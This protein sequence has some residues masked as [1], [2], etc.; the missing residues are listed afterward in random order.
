MFIIKVEFICSST[1]TTLLFLYSIK[2]LAG[3]RICLSKTLSLFSLIVAYF[4][5][6]PSVVSAETPI[7]VFSRSEIPASIFNNFLPNSF[8]GG[9]IHY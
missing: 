2:C 5:I 1:S 3:A 7:F 6:K 4:V 8:Q 9:Y